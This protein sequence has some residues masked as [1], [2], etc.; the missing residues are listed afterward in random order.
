MTIRLSTATRNAVA[1]A[2]G[3]LADSGSGAATLKIYTGS[4][5]ATA[6]STA[7][8]TLLAT[9]AVNDPAFDIASG[10]TAA[11]STTPAVTGTGI[12]AGDAGWFRLATS[13]GST[14]IDG[15]VSASGGGGNL[16][17]STV[18]VSIGL[19]LS[20]TSGSITMPAA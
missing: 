2:I 11:L 3:D 15:S 8:G 18:T 17:M 7:T 12:A 20:V 14:I 19:T 4:Q 16:I 10:G 1:D 6:D 5:P 13:S 9:I